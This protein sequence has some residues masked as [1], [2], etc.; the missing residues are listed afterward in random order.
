MSDDQ[1][2]DDVCNNS[3][4][5][6][7]LRLKKIYRLN[8]CLKCKQWEKNWIIYKIVIPKEYGKNKKE[9]NPNDTST[10]KEIIKSKSWWDGS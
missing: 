7:T 8:F 2:L 3:L 6:W 4:I 9:L 5:K 10:W 1:S